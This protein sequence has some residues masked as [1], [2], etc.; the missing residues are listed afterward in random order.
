[1]TITYLLPWWSYVLVFLCSLAAA[2]GAY[3]LHEWV[4]SRRPQPEDP[5][6]P[7][8]CQTHMGTDA[9]GG[10][11]WCWRQE[12]HDGSHGWHELYCTKAYEA[13]P[14]DLRHCVL[15]YGHAG[16]HTYSTYQFP[17]QTH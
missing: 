6:G 2:T 17:N 15:E 11:L 5:H 13:G 1:M 14:N 10:E 3:Y 9:Y 8:P 12:N 7:W 4:E 16:L